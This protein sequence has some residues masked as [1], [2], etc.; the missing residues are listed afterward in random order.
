MSHI[1]K[2]RLY[3]GLVVVLLVCTG[4]VNYASLTEAYGKGPPYYGRTTNMDKWE[5]PVLSLAL[6]DVT[7]LSGVVVALRLLKLKS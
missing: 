2:T 3:W 5:D 7:I 1:T 4:W 6:L